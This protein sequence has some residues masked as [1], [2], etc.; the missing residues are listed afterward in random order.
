MS[1]ATS[2]ELF[3]RLCGG[4]HILD[5]LTKEP[6]LY[7]TV[8]PQDW[9]DWFQLQDIS[10]ILDL[11]MREDSSVLEALRSTDG[12]VSRGETLWR[13]SQ[14]PPVSLLE[15]ILTIRRHSLGR[16][17]V[18]SCHVKDSKKATLQRH[19]AVGMKPKKIHEVQNFVK[20][21]DDLSEHI[22]SSSPHDISHIIDFGS[23]QNYL[24]RALASAPYIRRVVALESK[25]LNIDGARSMDV[26]AK[27]VEK[28]KIMRNK[29]QYRS[30]MNS[31]TPLMDHPLL[32]TPATTI[33][34]S[35]PSSQTFHKSHP[36]LVKHQ[37][38][39]ITYV[40]MLI[41]NGDLSQVIERIPKPSSPSGSSEPQLM[42]TSLHSCGNLLHHGVRSLMLNASVKAVAV[43]GCCYN[44]VTERLGPPTYKLPSLRS[45]NLRLDTTS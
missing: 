19:V 23:G 6:D 17:F 20:Y 40:E 30:E 39:R 27:L 3:Q 38:E 5:F 22:A 44:L 9:R 18:P 2:C 11:L 8:L 37:D 13:D 1:F 21:I 31:N 25:Q 28:E 43:V 24:G 12:K 34:P 32:S 14:A 42:V 16:D 15:Y 45:S 35:I 29:K 41:Q 10:D 4:V 33:S 36:V 26:H 7:S